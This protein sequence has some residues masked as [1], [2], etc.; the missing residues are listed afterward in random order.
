[1]CSWLEI[2]RKYANA[3]DIGPS[4]QSSDQSVNKYPQI[5]IPE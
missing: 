5:T 2:A 4:E 1:M 3:T